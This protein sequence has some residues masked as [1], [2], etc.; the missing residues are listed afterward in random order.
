MKNFC[1]LWLMILSLPVAAQT[2]VQSAFNV[3]DSTCITECKA[4]VQEFK[5]NGNADRYQLDANFFC[6]LSR[7]DKKNA[8]SKLQIVNLGKNKVMSVTILQ[9]QVTGTNAKGVSGTLTADEPLEL[10]KDADFAS[11]KTLSLDLGK[12]NFQSINLNEVE[13]VRIKIAFDGQEKVYIVGKE[14]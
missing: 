1:T 7:Y 14:K 5:K 3:T 8:A 12:G 2:N 10:L 6:H 9:M 4:R 11:C 13:S